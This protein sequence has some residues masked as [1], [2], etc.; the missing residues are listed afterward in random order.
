MAYDLPRSIAI[1]DPVDADN[2]LFVIGASKLQPDKLCLT[3]QTPY[4]YCFNCLPYSIDYP[5]KNHGQHSSIQELVGELVR[6]GFGRLDAL[7]CALT[8]Y[9]GR[10]EKGEE[11][12]RQLGP[13]V[14]AQM[15][16]KEIV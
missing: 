9:H 7:R 5:G 6:V 14:Q 11:R 8:P 10:D 1:S 3:V 2:Q 15:L 4:V 13:K 16:S 12:L